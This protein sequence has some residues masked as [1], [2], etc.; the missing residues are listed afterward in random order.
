MSKN[1][2]D[3]F[4][5]AQKEEKVQ[6][7]RM[8]PRYVKFTVNYKKQWMWTNLFLILVSVVM[9][10]GSMFVL[11]V[12]PSECAGIRMVSWAMFY[13]HVMNFLTACLCLCGLEKKWCG[14]WAFIA[15]FV[16][17]GIILVWANVTY[18]QSQKETCINS[19]A[20]LYFW[21]MGEIMFYYVFAF[22]VVCFFFRKFC[23]DPN[24]KEDRAAREADV[25][26]CFNEVIKNDDFRQRYSEYESN[27]RQSMY[28]Q[29]ATPTPNQ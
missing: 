21:L 25:E 13:L 12:N 22:M 28:E 16:V 11:G 20:P 4:T 17:V 14:G 6:E 26:K 9:G 2:D 1:I 19:N 23:D 3:E 27:Y 5:P 15:F 29:Q 24:L 10:V 7:S 8:P 18:F